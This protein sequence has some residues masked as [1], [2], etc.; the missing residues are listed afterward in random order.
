M[1]EALRK[2]ILPIIVI[3]LFFFV[4]M[5]VLEWGLGISGRGQNQ[6]AN[7]AGVINGEE[8]SWQTFSTTYSNLLQ[9]ERASKG[10]DYDIPDERARQIEEQAWNQLVTDR[11]LRQ[12]AQKMN[13][14]VLDEDVYL[15]LKY[16]PP[17]FIRQEPSLQTNG[18][19]DY[20]KYL[21]L[22]QDPQAAGLWAQIEPMV[23]N[24]LEN[25]GSGPCYRR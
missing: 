4:A 3:V 12:A 14:V 23:R 8:I 16:S 11:L 13:I 6:F 20:N 2:M 25:N 1:F 21:A 17:T 18:Q 24:D 10:G 5:I 9:D 15:Y 7:N 19:F 22:M